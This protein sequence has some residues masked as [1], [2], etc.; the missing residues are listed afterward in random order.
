[1]NMTNSSY[2]VNVFNLVL[3]NL[4]FLSITVDGNHVSRQHILRQYRNEY[5]TDQCISLYT[6]H[7]ISI[8]QVINA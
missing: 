3:S 1:M 4:S 2:F 5:E 8:K 7:Y 6:H